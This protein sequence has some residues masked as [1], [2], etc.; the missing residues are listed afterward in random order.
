MILTDLNYWNDPL[1][2]L[3]HA[4]VIDSIISGEMTNLTFLYILASD[5][6]SWSCQCKNTDHNDAKINVRTEIKLP[7][8]A[9][10]LFEAVIIQFDLMQN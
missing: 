4:L 9:Y 10:P 7:H 3:Y 2:P 6:I 8:F 1:S 5:D